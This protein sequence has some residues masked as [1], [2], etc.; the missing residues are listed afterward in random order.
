MKRVDTIPAAPGEF[1]VC[2]LSRNRKGI[3]FLIMVCV[4]LQMEVRAER[5]I[6]HKSVSGADAPLY[7]ELIEAKGPP[8]VKYPIWS[9][10]S[11]AAFFRN[12]AKKHA[13]RYS[14]LE[15]IRKYDNLNMIIR[16]G[17]YSEHPETKNLPIK[18]W[19][20]VQCSANRTA[21]A[22]KVVAVKGGE[23]YCLDPVCLEKA[24]RDIETFSPKNVVA[25]VLGEELDYR[26][27]YAIAVEDRYPWLQEADREIKAKYG[28]GKYGM[29]LS[30]T[31]D[32][33]FR[34]IAFRRWSD[35]KLTA[36]LMKVAGLLRKRWPE[37][38]LM[39]LDFVG[40]LPVDVGRLC[41]PMDVITP[42]LRPG[43]KDLGFGVKYFADLTGK[44]VWPMLQLMPF[45]GD[46]M[47]PTPETAREMYNEVIRNG[48]QGVFPLGV[49]WYARE[50]NHYKF[51][52]PEKWNAIIKLTAQMGSIKSIKTPQPADTVLF[53]S[54]DS[55]GAVPHEQVR[56]GLKEIRMAYEVLGPVCRGAF[57][58]VNDRQIERRERDL[59]R[60]RLVYVPFAT[61]QSTGIVNKF[62]DFV[63]QGG[64]LVCGDPQAF[65][66]NTN[67]EENRLL[68][69]ELLGVQVGEKLPGRQTLRINDFQA[70]GL[71]QPRELQSAGSA[72]KITIT[73]LSHTKVIATFQNGNPA[74]CLHQIG[75]G[76]ALY[77]ASNP[78]F[79]VDFGNDPLTL[80]MVVEPGWQELMRSIHQTFGGRLDQDIWRFSF[81]EFD[82]TEIA[83]QTPPGVCLTGNYGYFH[84]NKF[85]ATKNLGTGGTYRYSL[86]P[87]RYPDCGEKEIPFDRGKLMDRPR[88]GN[89]MDN[90][91]PGGWEKAW[92]YCNESDWCVSWASTAPIEVTFDLKRIYPLR[93]FH[94]FYAGQLP[95][96]ELFGSLNG[97]DWQS[98]A[99]RAGQE[100]TLD[101]LDVLLS[102]G[103][104]WRYLK[105]SMAKRAAKESLTLVETEI[106]G[107]T[108]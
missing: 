72:Y 9:Y 34:W 46:E 28:F 24:L 22:P 20:V 87:D 82:K 77:F 58:F 102:L 30:N 13:F 61:Y 94:L 45:G 88:A 90:Q 104:K 85:L 103:G 93:S 101:V 70:L 84:A 98:L 25:F 10:E 81:P 51:S 76:K 2:P 5:T 67:G 41:A 91:S 52:Y 53:Y 86:P 7:E 68:A 65:I 36:Q 18:H 97:K 73:D 23:S 26:A 19:E 3:G 29:P 40:V 96:L 56:F 108:D 21:E 44:P 59:S 64:I 63:K 50:L 33:P 107:G 49:E 6:M 80:E 8:L 69:Q 99:S 16:D 38:K 78:F 42:Q 54:N 15:E 100:P 35:D 62:L 95:A 106:W 31:D 105:L 74:I 60:Y 89:A 79:H 83:V 12:I 48:G 92:P 32:N 47:V 17:W 57:K 14:L 39:G 37:A 75:K 4:A 1:P 66:W 43:M 71:K 11:N 27:N 55:H